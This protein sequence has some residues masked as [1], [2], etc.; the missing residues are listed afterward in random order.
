MFSAGVGAVD[1]RP[2]LGT[3]VLLLAVL[4]AA[5]SKEPAP[6]A[7]GP[8][9]AAVSA[10]T[11]KAQTLPV[12]FQFVGQTESAQQVEIRA[13][14]DG[15][16]EKRVYREGSFVKP[17]EPLF[18]MDRKPFEADLQAARAELAQQ[19]A[20]LTTAR[21]NLA[22][23]KPL[24]ADN[25]LAAKDLDDATGQA[26][27]AAAAVEAANAK[28]T[29]SQL[30]LG[31]TTIASPLAGLSS[32]AKVQEGAYVSASNSLLTYVA[33]LD[34]MRVNFSLSENESLRVK[35]E[36]KRGLLTPA[37]GD[38]YGVELVLADGSVFPAKGRIT[39]ADAAF[40]QET[41]TFLL[42]AELPNPD[43]QLR[44]G[45][46]V[47]VNVIGF[48][49]PGAI[50]VPQ[51]AVQEGPRGQ[52]VWVVDADGKANQRPVVAGDW[53]GDQWLVSEGLKDG[54]RVVVDGFMRLAPGMAVQAKEVP[55]Q[56]LPA[57]AAGGAAAAS[58]A[59]AP[60]GAGTA[61]HAA[62]TASAGSSG[63]APAATTGTGAAGATGA[64]AATPGAPAPAGAAPRA[65]YFDSDRAR[66]DATGRAVLAALAAEL[67][68][69]PHLRVTLQGYADSTG[70]AR[71][72]R[73][74][75]RQ[76]AQAV[77]DA[78]V[79]AGVPAGR[80][81]LRKPADITGGQAPVQARRVDIALAAA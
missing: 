1:A 16:L 53:L 45:Q 56:A 38:R 77:R 47:R 22:R 30:R 46:F 19:Q 52:F 40:S 78:L 41:G 11:V 36:V 43:G 44:P 50:A 74:L 33:R 3:A 54:E 8:G 28:V 68:A 80:I 57:P 26:Q 32:F 42:R 81:E 4:V 79:A 2:V 66:V 55:A 71:R 24:V 39:F 63:G 76:R 27:A 59:S 70:S 31:Y 51:R 21:A 14:V 34:P 15:F 67:K 61:A 69:K 62:A 29:D 37:P 9:A 58:P 49:R 64:S 10:L 48:S 20:R 6:A 65:V 12:T 7:A 18:L 72:N 73:A 13:R 35:D 25:A 23:V 17:G 75:A 60:A 5:C